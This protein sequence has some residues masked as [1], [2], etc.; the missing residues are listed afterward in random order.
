MYAAITWKIEYLYPKEDNSFVALKGVFLATLGI[1]KSVAGTGVQMVGEDPETLFLEGNGGRNFAA[2]FASSKDYTAIA[3]IPSKRFYYM[4]SLADNALKILQIFFASKLLYKLEKK[5]EQTVEILDHLCKNLLFHDFSSAKQCSYQMLFNFT[6]GMSVSFPFP[7]RVLVDV[8]ESL[9]I[10]MENQ[11]P[12]NDIVSISDPMCLQRGYALY[13]RGY[14]VVSNLSA[15]ELYAVSATL[16]AHGLHEKVMDGTVVQRLYL[17]ERKET[18]KK[19]VVGVLVKCG[20]FVL[21]EVL[22]VINKPL[23]QFDPLYIQKS[24]YCVLVTLP[25]L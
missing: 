9:G 21:A 17:E 6:S 13:Y 11:Y 3:V 14:L 4:R 18:E 10:I 20:A 16:Y 19:K 1:S 24:K 5:R 15:K 22:H 12:I 8:C 7:E 23:G 2:L 25:P